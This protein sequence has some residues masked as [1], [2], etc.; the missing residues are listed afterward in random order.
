MSVTDPENKVFNS[1]GEDIGSVRAIISEATERANNTDNKLDA[2]SKFKVELKF[3]Y[4]YD[5][6]EFGAPSFV[7]LMHMGICERNIVRASEPSQASPSNPPTKNPEEVITYGDREELDI[8]WRPQSQI[9]SESATSNKAARLSMEG[10][11]PT[12]D[13]IPKQGHRP[14]VFLPIGEEEP[15]VCGQKLGYMRMVV[16]EN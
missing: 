1:C 16:T 8:A 10:Q 14:P 6:V 9:R 15:Y 4:L 11:Y 3:R 7:K 12:R 2:A 5:S 13:R